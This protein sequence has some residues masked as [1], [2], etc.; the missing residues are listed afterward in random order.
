MNEGKL[1]AVV[2]LPAGTYRITQT[3]EIMESNVVLRG[4][5]VRCR[6]VSGAAVTVVAAG[7]GVLQVLG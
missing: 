1:G 5:G 3:L 7:C 4:A 2:W 6:V